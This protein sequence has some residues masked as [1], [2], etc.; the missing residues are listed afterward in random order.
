MI[1]KA[2]AVPMRVC[3]RHAR[4]LPRPTPPS[5]IPTPAT[6][7][8]VLQAEANLRSAW[9]ASN[10]T[11]ILAPISGYVVRRSVQV[12]QQVNPAT[13]MVAIVPLER[14]WIDANFKETQLAKIRIGQPVTVTADIYGS[15]L[16]IPRHHPRAGRGHRARRWRCCRRKTPPATG[17][18]SCSGC[19]CASAWT[20]MN[21]KNIRCFS[22]CPPTSKWTFMTS[23]ARAVRAAHLAGRCDD[24]CVCALRMRV[25]KRRLQTI[26]ERESP[27]A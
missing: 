7:P 27:A 15:G 8:R 3:A 4:R 25:L 18:R 14:V 12:G 1:R 16:E 17:S 24:R 22:G 19:P 9:I 2:P 6:H 20:P 5:P 10:S 23:P 26:L 11:R 21:C 13:D